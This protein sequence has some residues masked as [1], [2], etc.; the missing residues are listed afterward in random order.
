MTA[1]VK[2]TAMRVC[3]LVTLAVTAT[4]GLASCGGNGSTATGP[5]GA[6]PSRGSAVELLWRRQ[7]RAFAAGIVVQLR[8]IQ[9]ATGGG[10]KTGPVGARVDPRV[11]AD[12]AGRRSFLRAVA[13]LERCRREVARAVPRAPAAGLAAVRTALAQACDVFAS[14]ARSLRRAVEPPGPKRAVDPGALAFA[15]S[16]AQDGVRLVV[17]ALAILARV[18]AGSG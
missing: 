16:Q 17:D 14:A 18:P 4:C 12:G 7:V 11:L 3:L 1:A 5:Q 13:A 6:P 9:A 2:L 15:R 8:R 10:S